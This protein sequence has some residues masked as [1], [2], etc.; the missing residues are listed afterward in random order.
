MS[1]T[2]DRS[3]VGRRGIAG[4]K[5][6][7]TGLGREEGGLLYTFPYTFL[8]VCSYR[9]F[10]FFFSQSRRETGFGVMNQII[11]IR[12]TNHFYMSPS[13]GCLLFFTPWVTASLHQGFGSKCLITA[14][15]CPYKWGLTP[16]HG[17]PAVASQ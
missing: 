14:V 13:Y 12:V 5:D 6:P 4:R 16:T 10:R 1:A 3:F 2:I 15:R 7:R 8:L 17:G 11:I 9:H